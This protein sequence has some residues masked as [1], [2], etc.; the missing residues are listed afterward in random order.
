MSYTAP[1][2]SEATGFSFL[3]PE[4]KAVNSAAE[5][6]VRRRPIILQSVN[7]SKIF[8]MEVK[9]LA[10]VACLNFQ[11][12]PVTLSA[13]CT[14]ASQQHRYVKYMLFNYVIEPLEL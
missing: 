1:R 13:H 7:F 14:I 11:R 12:L 9:S 10:D 4:T 3:A 8:L 2:Q 5:L 6:S